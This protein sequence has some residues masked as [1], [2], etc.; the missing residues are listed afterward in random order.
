MN[1]SPSISEAT[2]RV[3]PLVNLPALIR[4]V[5]YD[6]DPIFSE[7]G[8][9]SS[10]FESPDHR[11]P[12][13]RASQLLAG[14]AEI[15]GCDQLGFLLGQRADPSHLGIAGFL[16]RA[17]PN[18]E[19][20]LQTLVKNLDLHDEG[21]SV[22]LNIGD[23]YTTLGF[24]VH[25]PGV[26]ATAHIYDLSLCVMYKIMQ[27]VCGNDWV[28]STV[29]FKRKEPKDSSAYHHFF[30]SALFFNS[31]EC[32]ITFNNMYLRRPS[33]SGDKLLF[34]FLEHEA[35]NLHDLHHKKIVE[36]LPVVLAK[37][38][39]SGQFSASEIADV[40]GLRERTLHRRL[41]AA[42]TSY[43]QEID[44]ARQ[45]LSKQLLANTSLP[46]CD[47]ANALGYADSSGFIRAFS[48]CNGNSPVSW[49]KSNS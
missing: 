5:S 26:V 12:Y 37:G 27:A 11:I 42:G 47:I 3:G 15:T 43:R 17:A 8:F 33:Q 23:E 18:V 10:E 38:L 22:Y 49:R 25:L 13:V 9:N 32:S 30:H 6:P 34:K 2:S 1:S 29:M 40:F 14:C 16:M 35:R 44:K 46:V 45:A 7:F 4:S 24:S 31:S 48:R 39:L 36:E 41:R 19:T 28:A 21:G 20:A